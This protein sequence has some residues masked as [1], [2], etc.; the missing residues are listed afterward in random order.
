VVGQLLP[1]SAQNSEYSSRVKV[2]NRALYLGEQLLLRKRELLKNI[3][4]PPGITPN[5]W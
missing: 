3:E 4:L 2:S 1:V 5:R